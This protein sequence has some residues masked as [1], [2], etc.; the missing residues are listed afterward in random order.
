[1]RQQEEH[2]FANSEL[3][4]EH[5][6]I[7]GIP[8]LT[9]KLRIELGK[10]I[11]RCLPDIESELRTRVSGIKQTLGELQP[12]LNPEDLNQ[13]LVDAAE[14]CKVSVR[15]CAVS[16]RTTCSMGKCCSLN[17]IRAAVKRHGCTFTLLGMRSSGWRAML[18]ATSSRTQSAKTSTSSGASCTA[19]ACGSAIRVHSGLTPMRTRVY[20]SSTRLKKQFAKYAVTS[21]VAASMHAYLA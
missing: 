9:D 12:K 2:Y 15:V 1:M 16:V 21:A 3:Y 17:W 18:M 19:V 20:H 10:A 13:M 5:R 4:Q 6:A 11:E 7:C 14:C 8:F